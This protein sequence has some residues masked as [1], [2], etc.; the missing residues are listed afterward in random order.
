MKGTIR[1]IRTDGDPLLRKPSVPV[2]AGDVDLDGDLADLAV[3]LEDFRSRAG[4]GR[5]ISAPQIGIAKRIIVMNL[6][7]GPLALL[8]PEITWRSQEMQTVWDDCLSVP[9]T[10]VRVKRHA[11]IT[12]RYREPGFGV[13]TWQ[14]LPPDL[15][16]LLQHEIDH[17]DGVLMLDRAD[18]VDARGSMARRAELVDAGRRRHRIT[19]DGVVGARAQ[20]DPTFMGTPQFECESLGLSLDCRVTLKVETMNPI[21][22][23]KGRGASVYVRRHVIDRPRAPLVTASAGNWGQALAYACRTE[24]VDLVVYAAVGANPRKVERM[25]ALGA[26]VRLVGE[27]FDAAKWTA[28]K[29]AADSGL[30]Y[31]EDGLDVAVTEACGSVAIE[32]HEAVATREDYLDAIVVPLGNG[33][34]INGMASWSKAISPSTELIGVCASGAPSMRDSWLAPSGSPVV[35]YERIETVADGIGV[36]VPIPEAVEDMRGVVDDVVLV[37][38]DIIAVAADRLRE[39][40]GLIAEPAGAAALAFIIAEPERFSGRHV[41]IVVTGS[42]VSG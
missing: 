24:G 11:S 19:P 41:A 28:K 39:H 16:E 21:R 15:A 31:A 18:G 26:E 20:I 36:R 12:V 2:E 13:R 10:L 9:D 27:D 25:R 29:Y 33:A 42:N 37:D 40:A 1:P 14:R 5:A 35:A 22:C 4:F 7:A 32:L 17:L 6:G 3:T 38:D 34:L 23:F 30:A 8:N